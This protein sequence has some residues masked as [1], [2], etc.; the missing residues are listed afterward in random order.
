MKKTSLQTR[1]RRRDVEFQFTLKGDFDS[2]LLVVNDQEVQ[3]N[4]KH[5]QTELEMVTRK[6]AEV[7]LRVAPIDV[8]EGALISDL[9]SQMLISLFT[10]AE[11]GMCL[12]SYSHLVLLLIKNVK[13]CMIIYCVIYQIHSKQKVLIPDNE[14]FS[15]KLTSSLSNN[16][17]IVIH[18]T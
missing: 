7:F 12:K 10:E 6:Q 3:V 9:S 11:I 1:R 13:H 14:Y 18:T 8:N 17:Q 5:V 16:F 2:V 15:N 4:G